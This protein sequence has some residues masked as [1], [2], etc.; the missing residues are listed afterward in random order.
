[1]GVAVGAVVTTMTRGV[2]V[3]VG[4][5]VPTGVTLGVSA[6]QARRIIRNPHS[7]GTNFILYFPDQIDC[8]ARGTLW[9]AVNYKTAA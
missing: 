2:G 9:R 8:P 6:P 3:G 7:A 5:I 1:M 4:A